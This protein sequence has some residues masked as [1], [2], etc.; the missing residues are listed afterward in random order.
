MSALED[1]HLD[2]RLVDLPPEEITRARREAERITGHK[3]P[4]GPGE[5]AAYKKADLEPPKE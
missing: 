1:D 4:P 2:L 3:F 5:F